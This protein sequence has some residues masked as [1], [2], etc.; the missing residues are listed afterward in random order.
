M[1]WKQSCQC[2]M[3]NDTGFLRVNMFWQLTI[4]DNCL[5]YKYYH[6]GP[7]WGQQPGWLQ[8]WPLN[9]TPEFWPWSTGLLCVH[10]SIQV[11]V[12]GIRF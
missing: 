4:G 7:F 6:L 5:T 3:S 8:P 11:N 2:W 1:V 9:W 10:V 12:L